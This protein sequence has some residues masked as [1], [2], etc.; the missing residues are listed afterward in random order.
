MDKKNKCRQSFKVKKLKVFVFT[1][2]SKTLLIWMFKR[3]KIQ[4]IGRPY[5]N[6]KRK[7]TKTKTLESFWETD[8]FY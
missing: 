7:Q 6:N 5:L 3:Q 8:Y 4:N 2:K 1:T